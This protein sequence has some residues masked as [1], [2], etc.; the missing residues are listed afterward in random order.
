MRI[1]KKITGQREFS[2]FIIVIVIFIIMSFVSP[3]FLTKI[4]IHSLLLSLSV[5]AII[6]VGMT[7]LLISGGFDLSVGS[8]VGFTG[9]LAALLVK[10]FGLPTILSVIITLAIGAL[11]GLFHGLMVAKVGINPFIVTLAG[12]SLFRGLTY[13]VNDGQQVAQL[14]NVFEAIGQKEFLGIQLPIYYAFVFIIIGDFLLRKNS[15]LRQ[16]Y[17]IGGNENAS[18]LLGIQ[19]DKVKI[20]NYVLMSTIAAFA[21][22]V[23]VSR[24]G[25]AMVYAGTG[26]ELKVITA[27][28][29]GGASLSGGEG[30]AIGAFLGSLIMVLIINILSLLS[31]SIYWQTFVIG[32]ILL[33]AVTL[34]TL[35]M[36]RRER[37]IIKIPRQ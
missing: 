26:L 9:M 20:I 14:G 19:V 15:F 3:Y 34:D 32:A 28:I 31:I 16:N 23:M 11:I 5:T 7:N 37:I 25:A 29:I 8:V 24:M 10:N 4:N 18:R 30:S 35:N 13:I 36:K 33:L 22:V 27:V 1:L 2:I 12:L 21:G 6:A 17:F